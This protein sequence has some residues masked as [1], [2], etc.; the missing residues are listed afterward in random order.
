MPRLDV[1]DGLTF[2]ALLSS[3]F[4]DVFFSF[5]RFLYSLDLFSRLQ[6]LFVIS[7]CS[8]PLSVASCLG[9]PGIPI[10]SVFQLLSETW[11]FCAYQPGL[12]FFFFLFL[13][14]LSCFCVFAVLRFCVAGFRVAGLRPPCTYHSMFLPDSFFS[15]LF[16]L[17]FYNARSLA[18]SLA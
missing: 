15:I 2:C 18:R 17:L 12:V 8:L 10:F 1:C 13:F 11:T 3:F 4:R 14:F 6:V 7:H 16:F 9:Y 5:L